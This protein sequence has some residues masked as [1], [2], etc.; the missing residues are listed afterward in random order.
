MKVDGKRKREGK[1]GDDYLYESPFIMRNQIQSI[2]FALISHQLLYYHCRHPFIS[3][4][5]S[6]SLSTMSSEDDY[7]GAAQDATDDN[8]SDYTANIVTGK[9]RRNP[10]AKKPAAAPSSR[11]R[12]QPP[13]RSGST[14]PPPRPTVKPPRK[15]K[16]IVN[17]SSEDEAAIERRQDVDSSDSEDD[18]FGGGFASA[19]GFLARLLGSNRERERP[20]KDLGALALKPD[21]ASRPLWIDNR[22][23]M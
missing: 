20:V 10:A 3:P 19:S 5:P 13:T 7:T 22:G 12:T 23:K 17:S 15:R 2:A 18:E 16:A 14:S 11:S 21:H 6:P 4:P 8:I 1:G 9:R